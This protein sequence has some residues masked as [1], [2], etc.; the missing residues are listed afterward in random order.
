MAPE[1]QQ[2]E[3][4]R[5]AEETEMTPAVLA[6][7]ASVLLSWYFFFVEGD[8]ERGLFVGLWPPTILAFASYFEQ[9]RMSSRLERTVGNQLRERIDRMMQSK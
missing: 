7:A 2:Q 3:A 6:S 4:M 5:V 8:R 9:E 1:W